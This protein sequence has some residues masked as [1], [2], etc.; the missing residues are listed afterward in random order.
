MPV[1]AVALAADIAAR[2]PEGFQEFL[3]RLIAE[4][5]PEKVILFGSRARGEAT[6]DSDTDL[7]VVMACPEHPAHMAVRIRQRIELD[8]LDDIDL[9]VRAPEY[10][11]EKGQGHWLMFIPT[12]LREGQ[13]IYERTR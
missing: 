4:F 1:M 11:E 7:L 6:E 10:I 13:L 3:D 12:V 9:V 2:L 8:V 5:D